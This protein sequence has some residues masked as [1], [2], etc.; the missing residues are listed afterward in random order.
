MQ[1]NVAPYSCPSSNG[2]QREIETSPFSRA[3][4]AYH[5]VP[6]SSNETWAPTYTW[7]FSAFLAFPSVFPNRQLAYRIIDA[8]CQP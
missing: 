8:T 3:P 1:Q 2:D 7:S 4:A 5:I 6:R